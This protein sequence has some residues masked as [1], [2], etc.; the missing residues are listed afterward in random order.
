MTCKDSS[1]DDSFGILWRIRGENT[2]MQQVDGKQEIR[3]K[4]AFAQYR[5]DA[6]NRFQVDLRR[7]RAEQLRDLLADPDAMDLKTFNR[8]VWIFESQTL[9]DSKDITRKMLREASVAELHDALQSGALELHGNYIWGSG[10]RVYGSGLRMSDQQKVEY[11]H[12][13]LHMLNDRGLTPTEKAQH[14]DAI[15]GFGPNITTGLVM[16]FHPNEFAIFNGPSQDGARKSGYAWSGSNLESFEDAVRQLKEFLGAEDFLE[17]DLFLYMVSHD[18]I[19]LMSHRLPQG[20]QEPGASRRIV[21]IAPGHDANYWQD[22][23]EGGYIC[24]GWDEV[25]DLRQYASREAFKD[26]FRQLYPSSPTKMAA[27]A[28]EVW[29]LMELRPGDLIVANRGISQIV[30]IGEVVAPLYD[31]RPERTRYKHTVRVR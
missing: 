1:P 18:Q 23:L 26:R 21:K 8:E 13:A 6:T 14:I 12:Q 31:W 9:L 10:A 2:A 27:K 22:C 11:L 17:L 28:N 25:G 4:E 20:I 30:G 19:P 5:Q 29:T 24:V 7:K 16:V 3:L 15:P